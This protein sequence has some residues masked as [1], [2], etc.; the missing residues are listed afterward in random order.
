MTGRGEIE[1][2]HNT[3]VIGR[4]WR[5]ILDSTTPDWHL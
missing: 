5:A 4:V 2:S 1:V 3:T